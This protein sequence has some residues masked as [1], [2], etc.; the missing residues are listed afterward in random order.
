MQA[1]VI[2]EEIDEKDIFTYLTRRAGLAVA[3]SSDYQRVLKN[4]T[5]HPADIIIL[6]LQENKDPIEILEQVREITQVPLLLITDPLKEDTF[7]VLLEN[8]VDV[9]L[10]RPLSPRVLTAHI[11]ALSRRSASVPSFVLPDLALEDI[12]LDTSTRTVSVHN[13]E[14]RRL[15]QLEF[16]LLFTLMTNRGQ[17]VPTDILIERVWGY[18]GEGN[19]ELVRGLIS[20][21]RRKIETNGNAHQFIET[22]AGVGYR[23]IA[24]G[25]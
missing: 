23:F 22:I 8:G 12:A 20:R 9:L 2:A 6:A 5:D 10:Y 24:E 18:A 21:L 25:L 19:R 4:W 3:F 13:Q 16:R 7:C 1:I 17:V 15:T 11:H 14:P